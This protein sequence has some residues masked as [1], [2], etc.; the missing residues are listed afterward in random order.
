MRAPLSPYQID[1][2]PNEGAKHILPGPLFW[3]QNMSSSMVPMPKALIADPG[4]TSRAMLK[5]MIEEAG[6]QP[7]M[8]ATGAEAVGIAREEKPDIGLLAYR[9]PDMNGLQL[10]ATL[11]PLVARSAP[12]LLVTSEDQHAFMQEAF[13]A[14][15]TDVFQRSR[16]PQLMAYLKN[17]LGQTQ[18][19]ELHGARILLVEDSQVFIHMVTEMLTQCGMLV[20]SVT[21]VE[22]ARSLYEQND[23]QMVITDL[24]LEGGE[25]GLSLVR[26][27]RQSQQDYVKL[28]I[29]VMTGF[30]D[31][32][33]K[34]E[35]FRAGVND[36]VPKPLN[37]GEFMAR[38]RNLLI[39][40]HLF[41]RVEAQEKR[42]RQLA[43]TDQLTGLSNR[44]LYFEAASRYLARAEREGHALCMLMADIDF[45]KKIND[46]HGH[47]RG[48]D[49]LRA[50]GELLRARSR[51]GDIVARFGGEEFVALLPN[52]GVE[53]AI[54]KAEGLR[55]AAEQLDVNGVRMTLSVGVACFD[56]SQP[57][58]MDSLFAR[59]DAALY[60]A[61]R[62]GRNRVILRA[63]NQEGRS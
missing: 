19:S 31:P 57:E 9:L 44:H 18:C 61:K 5:R 55:Q 45:F 20:D 50:M 48:D 54:N 34:A 26:Y 62:Q 7:L 59:A 28:P 11:R 8:A 21:S 49:V 33:R 60:D 29:L 37:E 30:D 40:R 25:S 10:A 24:V 17:F 36:Y 1:A 58:S 23:Y 4:D 16:T 42:M 35:L 38:A 22:A 43:T 14:G 53:D 46:K 47:A 63:P 12:L 3:L 51:K 41:E 32:T 6:F 56:P 15:I 2:L 27:L 52:C 39:A 13:R